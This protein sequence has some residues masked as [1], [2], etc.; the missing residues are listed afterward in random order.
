[1]IASLV[2]LILQQGSPA[3]EIL[4]FK[5]GG[6]LYKYGYEQPKK[7]FEDSNPSILENSVLISE[8]GPLRKTII[9][10]IVYSVENQTIYVN[11][12]YS[13]V[14]GEYILRMSGT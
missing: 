5:D 7:A 9:N 2:N 8:D 11:R 12:S 13:I 14:A 6:N 1:M 10:S 4:I 3:N